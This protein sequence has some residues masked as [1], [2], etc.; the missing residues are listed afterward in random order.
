MEQDMTIDDF[1]RGMKKSSIAAYRKHWASLAEFFGAKSPRDMITL[2]SRMGY[3]EAHVMLA[4]WLEWR[5][6]GGSHG[7]KA[8]PATLTMA[9]SV[10]AATIARA[11]VMRL[12]DLCID[13]QKVKTDI[14]VDPCGVSPQGVALAWRS[15]LQRHDIKGVRDRCL[16]ALMVDHGVQRSELTGMEPHHVTRDRE[17]IRVI[18]KGQSV[19]LSRRA[20]MAMEEW[21]AIRP[22]GKKLFSNF[23]RN[24]SKS[25][26]GITGSAV[27]AM[28]AKLTKAA[29]ERISPRRLA[30]HARQKMMRGS[31]A[32]API[33]SRHG[34][35]CI[36]L[37][38]KFVSKSQDLGLVSIPPTSSAPPADT[39]HET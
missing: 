17:H 27:G 4:E 32:D 2:L 30:Y 13:L 15:L 19:I 10:I 9:V 33:L 24:T 34:R 16:F 35:I 39:L 25:R 12:T 7:N 14:Y 8:K 28:A 21:V 31:M 6:N 1:L 18:I 11:R 22:A 3:D 20:T 5:K 36:D 37:A 38:D 29:G 26:D 23:N